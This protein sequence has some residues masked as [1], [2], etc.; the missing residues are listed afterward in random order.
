MFRFLR[1]LSKTRKL[2]DAAEQRDLAAI[3]LDATKGDLNTE[4]RLV[5]LMERNGWSTA[6]TGDRCIH[7]VSLIR[8]LEPQAYE[9]AKQIVQELYIALPRGGCSSQSP[10]SDLNREG[11]N[12]IA[13]QPNGPKTPQFKVNDLIVYPAHGVGRIVQIE[14][15]EIGGVKLELY[16]I[17]FEKEKVRLKVPTSKSEQKGMRKLAESE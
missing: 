5:G 17:D 4:S 3:I 12:G 8:I 14:E 10:A 1:L 7:A 9:A 13:P 2:N 15:Q 6:E 11:A 16:V